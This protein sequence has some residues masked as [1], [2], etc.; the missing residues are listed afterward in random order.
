MR[1]TQATEARF[2]VVSEVKTGYDAAVRVDKTFWRCE[3]R[4]WFSGG[5]LGD[6]IVAGAWPDERGLTVKGAMR[7]AI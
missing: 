6:V 7:Q 3:T 2:L 1:T 5:L 4:V